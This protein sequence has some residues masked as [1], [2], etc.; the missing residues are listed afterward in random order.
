MRVLVTGGTGVVGKPAVR[1]LLARGHTVRLFS[2]N[3]TRDAQG[4]PVEGVEAQSGSVDSA[5][6]VAR[7]MADVD[8]VLHVA[9]I[10]EESPPEVT[11]EKVNVQGTRNLVEAAARA[12]VRRFV[13]VSSLGADRGQS[14]YHRSKRAAEEIARGFDGEWIV[15][16]PGNVYGP[17]DE[18]ISLL[19]KMVRT[20]PAIPT[21]DDGDQPF[22]PIWA[23]DLGE[24]IAMG[25]ERDDL[26]GHTLSLAGGERVST[27]EILDRFERLTDKHPPRLGVP[28]WL[29]AT[30]AKIASAFG[31]GAPVNA[32]QITMLTEG[33][34]I[35]AGEPNALTEVFGITPTPLD[36]GLRRLADELP[37]QLPEEGVGSLVRRRYWAEI[38]G[39]R[40]DADALWARFL[41]GFQEIAPEGTVEVGAEPGTPTRIEEGATLT[42][43]LPMRGHVQVRVAE[44]AGRSATFVTVSGHPLA[45]TVRFD[46]EPR[47]AMLRFQV[48]TYDRPSNVVDY[49]A[50][51]TVGRALKHSTWRTVVERM[52]EESGG[53]APDG[54]QQ[55]STTLDDEAADRAETWAE[56]LVLRLQRAEMERE[57]GR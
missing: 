40:L 10:V 21:V 25:V 42:L 7:A 49:L 46:L 57:L 55:E 39:S 11:F 5:D 50:I 45:G 44:V 54:V 3:A 8:A 29:A 31:I 6:A 30:G 18:V 9:G 16:R 34:L 1:S 13:Y 32:D 26:A 19:L 15:L 24:A 36:E 41:D 27:N 56:G 37:E 2:R 52:V 20:L 22:Q 23:E 35:P 14:A 53:E 48:T 47:G 28:A 33:N 38:A 51:Q 43:G 4:F 17:G 12:G